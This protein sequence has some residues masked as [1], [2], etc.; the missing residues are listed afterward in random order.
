MYFEF[1]LG[2][3]LSSIVAFAAYFKHSLSRSGLIAAIVLGTSMFYAGA[4]YESYV[5]WIALISFFITSSVLTKYRAT[6]KV[7][8]TKTHEKSGNRDYQQVL[9]N[10]LL[11]LLFAVIAALTGE[12]FYVIAGITTIAT[13]TADTW[14]SEIGI[15]SKGKTISLLSWK[16]V[17]QGTSGGV[18]VLGI[19][20]SIV[21]AGF[22]GM[23]FV[24][25]QYLDGQ[26]DLWNALFGFVV[27]AAGGLFGSILDS[28]LGVTLQ[29][30]YQG[31]ISGL[32]T[33][34]KRLENEATKLISGLS[35]MTNDVVNFTSSLASSLTIA[36]LLRLFTI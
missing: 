36:L 13:S 26:W 8:Y 9:A 10:G 22:I 31:I 2:F 25:M 4:V 1:F 16:E 12:L 27:I 23:I 18:S 21:G 3:L 29:A 33:E 19:I 14:A 15:L 17:P 30:R 6:D 5:I 7:Q 11:P 24:T 20:A 28:V 34:K 35:W 32:I